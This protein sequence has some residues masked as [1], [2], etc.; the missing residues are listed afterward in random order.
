[1]T[2]FGPWISPCLM[3]QFFSSMA[4]TFHFTLTRLFWAFCHLQVKAR[5]LT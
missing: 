3:L 1:M 4:T 5:D 2:S